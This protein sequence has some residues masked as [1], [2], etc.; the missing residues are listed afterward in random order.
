MSIELLF[1]NRKTVGR[2]LWLVIKDNGYTKSSFSKLTGI[3]RPTL[4]KLI[5]GDIN[6]LATFENH[7][8]KIFDKQII[9]ADKLL[10]YS[11]KYQEKEETK[12]A[13]SDNAPNE[14]SRNSRAQKMFDILE[15]IVHLCELYQT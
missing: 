4:N 6:N 14:H 7:L 8:Q 11:P 3:S 15:D 2:K 1:E 5:D 9:N 13:L 10:K 12:L